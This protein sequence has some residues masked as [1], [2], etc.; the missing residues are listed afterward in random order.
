MQMA[1]NTGMHTIAFTGEGGGKLAELCD[2]TL[3]VPSTVN[4]TNSRDAYLG[5]SYYLRAYR[6]RLLIR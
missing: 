4:C 6:R 2:I 3:A 5:R 1:R